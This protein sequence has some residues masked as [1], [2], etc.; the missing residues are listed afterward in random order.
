MIDLEKEIINKVKFLIKKGIPLEEMAERV[1]LS[2]EEIIGLAMI[3]KEE[4]FLVD[5]IDGELVKLKKPIKVNDIYEIPHNLERLKLLLISDTHLASRYDRVDILRYLYEKAEDNGV[6]YVLHAGDFS[7]GKSKRPEHVYELKEVSYDGQVDYCVE[8]YPH[9]SGKTFTIA[10]NHD[11]WWYK[12]AG[13]DI[14]KAIS[15]RRDDIIYLGPDVADMK[16]GKLKIRLFHGTG[17]N[18][19]AK[20]YKLQKYLDAIPID[21][22][23]H[24]LQT[25]H[26]HQAFYYKQDNTHCLQTGC[27]EDLTPYAR[28]LGFNGDKSCWWLD[29]SFDDNGKVYTVTPTLEVFEGKKLIR[30]R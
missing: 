8:K 24:I 1:G 11:L 20:S 25:G 28:T 29:V 26:I 22:K 9:F 21:E 4:G 15:S 14:V 19:Y 10:G 3:L 2:K 5:Y 23:P 17:G 12:S 27:L 7:D 16:I 30:R 6:K 13:A 18:S